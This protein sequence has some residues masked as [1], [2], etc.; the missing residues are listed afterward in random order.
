MLQKQG[1]FSTLFL[2]RTQV[3]FN[4]KAEADSFIKE[5]EKVIG[6]S[7]GNALRHPFNQ[8]AVVP[9]NDEYLKKASHLLHKKKNF[10]QK[11]LP[12]KVGILVI[13]KVFL[14]KQK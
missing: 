1:F 7:W 14:L 3:V 4:T 5:I 8:K 12:S 6:E 9:W 10:L 2:Y 11:M 13:I